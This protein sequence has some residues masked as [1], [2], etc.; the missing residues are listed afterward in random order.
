MICREHKKELLHFLMVKTA[1]V[2]A[3][4]K[5]GTLLRVARCYRMKGS[6]HGGKICLHQDE[7]LTEL[8]LHFRI[9]KRDPESALV[10]FYDP[11]LLEKTLK[12]SAE[13]TCLAQYGYPAAG[14]AAEYLNHL[15][16]RCM[17]FSLPHEVGLFLGY[18]PKD[19]TGFIEKAPRTPVKRGDWQVFGDPRESLHR[20]RL[21][22]WVEHLAERIIER[23]QDIETCLEKI[24]DINITQTAGS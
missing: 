2:R 10:L 18:P 3:G 23:C 14:S 20:M 5:P 4:V 21:Y 7:I 8:R 19:V 22:R 24:A 16:K 17:E 1:G 15:E 12:G 6:T 9:L 13:A 11:F